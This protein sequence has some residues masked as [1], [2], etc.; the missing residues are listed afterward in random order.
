MRTSRARDPYAEESAAMVKEIRRIERVCA[1]G[2]VSPKVQACPKARAALAEVQASIAVFWELE[3]QARA[4]KEALA[5]ARAAYEAA[6][7]RVVA[8]TVRVIEERLRIRE[9]RR[10]LGMDKEEILLS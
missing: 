4:A 8:A 9:A 1:K 3:A 2:A 5:A 6:M 10:T 7:A